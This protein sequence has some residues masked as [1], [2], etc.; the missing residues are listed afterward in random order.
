MS[1]PSIHD[2]KS[3]ILRLYRKLDPRELDGLQKINGGYITANGK[4]IYHVRH[5]G[6]IEREP[7]V[8][9]QTSSEPQRLSEIYK[10][11]ATQHGLPVPPLLLPHLYRKP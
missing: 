4:W 1:N 6:F 7:A 5:G 10:G 9:Q 2:V 11:L 8:Q 3:Q